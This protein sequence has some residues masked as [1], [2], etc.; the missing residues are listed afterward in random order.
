[1]SIEIN[2]QTSPPRLNTREGISTRD[3]T[4]EGAKKTQTGDAS[5]STDAVSLTDTAAMMQEIQASLSQMPVVDTGKVEAIKAAIADG[6][7]RVD[8]EV[9]TD[10]LISFEKQLA[11]SL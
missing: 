6:S 1:M 10:R 5:L 7:Y 11:E 8:A 9:I 3:A 2:N 4:A